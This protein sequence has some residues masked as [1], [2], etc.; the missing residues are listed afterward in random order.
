MT[1]YMYVPCQYPVHVLGLL[2]SRSVC[3]FMNVN[4]FLHMCMCMNVNVFLHMSL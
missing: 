2:D 3:M 1:T 4:V